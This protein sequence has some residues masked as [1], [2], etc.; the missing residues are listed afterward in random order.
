MTPVDLETYV[1]DRYNALGDSFFTQPEIF[2]YFWAGQ[3]ELAQE[4]F[5]IR[6]IH[7]TVSV[8]SQRIYAYPTNALSIRRMT[9]DGQRVY[10]NDFIDDDTITGNKEDETLTG[11]P[12][13][14][15]IWND[16]FFLRPTPSVA[17]LTINMYTYDL[18]IQPIVG[19]TLDIPSRYH[20]FL[21]DYALY[22]MLSKDNNRALAADYLN[23]WISHKKLC[24]QTER[25]KD[26]GDSFDVVR[27]MNDISDDF[28]F[29]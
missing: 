15:Q 17:G 29:R 7:T 16:Q 26:S 5:C 23:L 1:R 2:N 4:A 14:Y 9:Y 6:K 3:M 27:D 19:G 13:H 20:L 28:R 18:P 12:E 24:L 22:C 25:L 8:I 21:A 10:P 11:V